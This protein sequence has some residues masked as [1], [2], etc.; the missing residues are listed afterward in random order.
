MGV[1]ERIERLDEALRAAFSR[2]EM[3]ERLVVRPLTEPEQGHPS[4][5]ERVR[6][7]RARH[8]AEAGMS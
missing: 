5:E 2:I 1:D 3:L 6:E 8:E 7:V 4:L